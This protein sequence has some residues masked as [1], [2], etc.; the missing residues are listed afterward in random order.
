MGRTEELIDFQRGTVIGCYI[1][2]KSI[3]QISALLELPRSTVSTVTVKWKRL[4]KAIAQPRS[5][6][7]HRFT[8]RYQRVL[9]QVARK[10]RLST[11]PTLT[12]EFQAASRSNVNINVV[13]REFHEMGFHGRVAAHK[14]KITIHNAKR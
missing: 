7:P 11:V 1:S 8:E 10:N 4:A 6:R 2:N 9:K 5:G 14:L 12:N 13:R 3:R